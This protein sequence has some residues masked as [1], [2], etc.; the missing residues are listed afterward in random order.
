MYYIVLYDSTSMSTGPGRC[1]V[2]RLC[3]S[4]SHQ[5]LICGSF[6]TIMQLCDIVKWVLVR[7]QNL[8][9][10]YFYFGENKQSKRLI[11]SAQSTPASGFTWGERWQFEMFTMKEQDC[12]CLN[13]KL[14]GIFL[15]CR[16]VSFIR[17]KKDETV[18]DKRGREGSLRARLH[19]ERNQR[20]CKLSSRRWTGNWIVAFRTFQKC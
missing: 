3:V 10:F 11:C 2:E 8:P 7:R 12:L 20:L 15:A 17:C 9:S 4:M 14:E 16:Y 13:W 6:E 5:C 18:T 1:P 19:W